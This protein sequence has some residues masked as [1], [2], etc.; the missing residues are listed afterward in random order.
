MRELLNELTIRMQLLSKSPHP[1]EN[2][3]DCVHGPVFGLIGRLC[4]THGEL[5]IDFIAEYLHSGSVRPFRNNNIC[6]SFCWFNELFVHRFDGI[7]ILL[8]YAVEIPTTVADVAFDAT[9]HTH[10]RISLNVYWK[11]DVRKQV[12]V[13]ESVNAFENDD[14]CRFHFDSFLPADVFFEVI[15]GL[16]DRY[17]LP[18]CFQ[19][20][21]HPGPLER[22]RMVVVDLSPFLE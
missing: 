18:Q 7:E 5:R 11:I 20:I 22:V 13:I 12:V 8:N 2:S 6:V 1:G 3:L 14:S 17:T 10:I 21:N 15:L 19:I 16:L 9:E 4:G